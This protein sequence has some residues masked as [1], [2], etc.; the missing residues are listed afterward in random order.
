MSLAEHTS[1]RLAVV[2]AALA[3]AAV[4][5]RPGPG[6][7][8]PAFEGVD[9]DGKAVSFPPKGAWAVLAFYP[10]AATPG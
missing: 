7:R 3:A 4:A 2:L 1:F 10:K 6:D 5:Q 9:Q 8:A